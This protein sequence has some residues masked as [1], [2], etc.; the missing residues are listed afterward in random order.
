MANAQI[1][2]GIRETNQFA[3][4]VARYTDMGDHLTAGMS[5]FLRGQTVIRDTETGGHARASDELA[6]MRMQANPNGLEA[7]PTSQYIKGIDY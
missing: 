3:A 5:D 1:V 2:Q 7:V 6:D 4:D